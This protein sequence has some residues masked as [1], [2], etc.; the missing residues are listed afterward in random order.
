M[1][2]V[3]QDKETGTKIDTFPTFAAAKKALADYENEDKR[4]GIYTLDFYEI[5]ADKDSAPGY[6][7]YADLCAVIREFGALPASVNAL[8]EW[9]RGYG[10]QYWNGEF[11]NVDDLGRLR[12]IFGE[13][14]N[15]ERVLCKYVL[16]V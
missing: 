16:D 4:E 12:P 6:Y 11:Y 5:E 10:F 1:K 15:G 3:I 13:D 2:F 8:G 14:E 7:D 9:F